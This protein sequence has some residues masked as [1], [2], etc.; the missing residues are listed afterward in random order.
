MSEELLYQGAE[1]K[2]V[3]SEYLGKKVI[4]KR[5]VSKSYRIAEIDSYL[6]SSRTREEAKLI[7]EARKQGVC[8]PILYDIDLESGVLTMQYLQG[9][10]MKDILNELDEKKR[11]KI[12]EKIGESIAYLHN[13]GIIHGDITTSNMILVDDRIYFID[14][15]L[16]NKSEEIEARGVDLHVLMEAFNSTHSNHPHCFDDVLEGYKKTYSSDARAVINKI[17]EIV[18]R[19]RYR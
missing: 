8:V 6:I 11:R 5:R 18:K 16:G 13:G 10:R 12:C 17:D 7:A 19:G 14:F 4:Q 1:A 15:G 3:V 2:I 9:D